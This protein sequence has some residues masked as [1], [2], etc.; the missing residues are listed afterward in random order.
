MR[1][2]GKMGLLCRWRSDRV[3]YE[4]KA[5]SAGAEYAVD[6]THEHGSTGQDVD[7]QYMMWHSLVLFFELQF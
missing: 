4:L 3:I 5:C 7:R 2:M 6:T 1:H